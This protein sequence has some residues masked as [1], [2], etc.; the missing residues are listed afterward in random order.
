MTRTSPIVRKFFD[1]PFIS[2]RQ[3]TVTHIKRIYL[4]DEFHTTKG[5]DLRVDKLHADQGPLSK[6][7]TTETARPV[8]H[9]TSFHGSPYPYPHRFAELLRYGLR[10]EL[11][12][13][14]YRHMKI[15]KEV[16]HEKNSH[17]ENFVAGQRDRAE[18]GN[19]KL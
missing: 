18:I 10:V 19:M 7:S 5:H 14:L 13:P 12:G 17:S 9:L 6:Q 3:I 11:D 16:S 4:P 2:A 1:T 8:I 15:Q